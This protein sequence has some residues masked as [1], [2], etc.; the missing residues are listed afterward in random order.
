LIVFLKYRP[1]SYAFSI[2]TCIYCTVLGL[3]SG[4]QAC[5][6]R[7]LTTWAAPL[8]PFLL[9]SVF[10][11]GS[12]VLPRSSLRPQS[13]YLC[14]LYGWDYRFVPWC[15]DFLCTFCLI[16]CL[17]VLR[18]ELRALCLLGRCSTAWVM[19]PACLNCLVEM[20][21]HCFPGLAL[22]SVILPI[23]TSQVVGITS[24]TYSDWPN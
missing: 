14:L 21:S 23:S 22:N 8:N 9:L 20:E 24:M 1:D 18:L 16:V 19:P 2:Y 10:W 7:T 6:E 15:L 17:V 12:W 11:V 5:Y 13:S 3:N 4:P